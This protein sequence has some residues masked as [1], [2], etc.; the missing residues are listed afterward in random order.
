MRE[1]HEKLEEKLVFFQDLDIEKV[2]KAQEDYERLETENIKIRNDLNNS[3][4]M[5]N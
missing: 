2:R 4:H 1:E 5:R 3:Q